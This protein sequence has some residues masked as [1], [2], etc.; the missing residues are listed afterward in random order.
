[1]DYLYV[2]LEHWSIYLQ[3]KAKD[4]PSS[5]PILSSDSIL[6]YYIPVSCVDVSWKAFL[7]KSCHEGLDSKQAA[8]HCDVEGVIPSIQPYVPADVGFASSA[9]N[10]WIQAPESLGD[11]AGQNL[12]LP[13]SLGWSDV[14]NSGSWLNFLS[15]TQAHSCN[16]KWFTHYM[17][18]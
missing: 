16:N 7:C 18:H 12:V 17:F 10:P 1:M 4:V 2:T 5:A 8:L 15:G 14:Q 3:Y 9:E 6:L 13:M 11:L